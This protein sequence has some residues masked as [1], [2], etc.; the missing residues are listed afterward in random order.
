MEF[1][2]QA[3]DTPCVFPDSRTNASIYRTLRR[4]WP[5]KV[6]LTSPCQSDAQHRA[7][8]RRQPYL[9]G[10]ETTGPPPT[11]FQV[12]PHVLD[13]PQ[14]LPAYPPPIKIRPRTQK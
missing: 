13:E 8:P 12:Q 5:I 6:A 3:R 1:H 2:T 7:D 9:A 11:L 4:F 14:V 10:N